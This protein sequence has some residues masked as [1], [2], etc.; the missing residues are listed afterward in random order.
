MM[1]KPDFTAFDIRD[2]G[3]HVLFR[4]VDEPVLH[5][6]RVDELPFVNDSQIL[7]YR[8]AGKTVKISSG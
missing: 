3:K 7:Q 6:C 1:V 8:A 4:R 2:I 5:V